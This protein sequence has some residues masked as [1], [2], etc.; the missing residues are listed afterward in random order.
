MES[1]LDDERPLKV[2]NYKQM[3]RESNIKEPPARNAA[4]AHLQQQLHD[5]RVTLR[6]GH[7]QRRPV[8]FGAGVSAHSGAQQ[9]LCGGVMAELSRQ[10][11]R[12]RAQLPDTQ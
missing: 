9:H 7:V 5:A 1:L 10:V 4:V 6:R 8:H 3:H 11:Q 12:R 2:A